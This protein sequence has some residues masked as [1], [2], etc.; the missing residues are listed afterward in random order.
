MYSDEE[1]LKLYEIIVQDEEC[2]E[3]LNVTPIIRENQ[4]FHAPMD[5][6][7]E[8]RLKKQ[9]SD[10]VQRNFL[11]VGK[12]FGVSFHGLENKIFSL[13]EEIKTRFMEEGKERKTV[14][15][16]KMKQ[17]EGGSRELK[18]LQWFVNYERKKKCGKEGVRLLTLLI[19]KTISWNVKGL[20]DRRK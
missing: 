6:T 12:M 11:M 20:N 9:Y 18:R 1:C 5:Q 2:E 19:G 15:K 7:K 13:L 8:G 17:G 14:K 16:S 4:W 3:G 10:W